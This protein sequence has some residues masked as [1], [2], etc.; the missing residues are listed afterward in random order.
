MMATVLMGFV[1]TWIIPC[2]RTLP[3]YAGAVPGPRAPQGAAPSFE[4]LDV[5]LAVPP[6][7]YK[8]EAARQARQREE[9]EALAAEAHSVHRW[10]RRGRSGLSAQDVRT[11]GLYV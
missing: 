1:L 11:G 8:A 10:K 2:R 3:C 9:A 5:P 4:D 7:R 6:P